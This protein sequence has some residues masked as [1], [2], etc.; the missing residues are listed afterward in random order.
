MRARRRGHIAVVASVAGDI[1]LPYAA[2]YSASKAALNRICQSL[3]AELEREGI[4]I[5]VI[6]P[7]FVRTPLTS[8]N[9]FPM[10]FLIDANRAAD[11]IR[12]KLSRGHFNIRF[13]WQMSVAMRLLAALPPSLTLLLTRRMLR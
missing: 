3:R 5:S 4:R 9:T 1:G 12:D 10:P 6:N 7:G 11:I 8:R 2:S 13:P